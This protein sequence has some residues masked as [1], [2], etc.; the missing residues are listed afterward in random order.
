MTDGLAF[1][2]LGPVEVRV[3][4]RPVDLPAGRQ[5]ALLAALLLADGTVVPVDRLV[6]ALWPDGA[7]PS[8]RNAVQ[9]Y[10]AR[11]RRT[12]GPAGAAV[13]TRPPGYLL[14]ARSAAR[15]D[16]EFLDLVR[17]AEGRLPGAPHEALAG[18]E[19]ALALW[20][21]PAWA[22]F[23]DSFARGEALRLEE[24]RHAA[25]ERRVELL[26]RIGRPDAVAAAE[27]LA[28]DRPL[29][30]R[31]VVLLAEALGAAGRTPEALAALAT[32]RERLREELGLDP[33]VAVTTVQARL[34]RGEVVPPAPVLPAPASVPVP[35]SHSPARPGR[36]RAGRLIGRDRLLATLREILSQASLVSLVGP[37]GVGKTRLAQ[38]VA[39]VSAPSWWVDLAPLRESDL[40]ARA[41]ADAVGVAVHPGGTAHHAL[42]AW[43]AT[44]DGLLVLDNCEH[45]LP[46]AA[47]VTQTVLAAGG[48]SRVLATSRERLGVDGEVVQPVAPLPV[49]VDGD[50]GDPAATDAVKLFLDRARRADPQFAPTV[51]QLTVIGELCRRLDGLPLAIE[52]AAAR[53]RGLAVEDLVARLDARLDLLTSDRRDDDER[54]RT[55]R[56]VIDWSYALLTP[57]ER[58]ALRALGAF[59]GTF[60]LAAAE[61]V[62]EPP[63]GTAADLVVRLVDRSVLHREPGPAP[64]RY[65][66]LES[67]R[68][69]VHDRT[70]PGEVA[71]GRHTRWVRDL[72]AAAEP[73]LN[74]PDEARW[75]ARV[76]AAVPDLRAA[77][78]RA[79][80]AGRPEVVAEVTARL[81][82][83]ACWRL[84]PDLLRW[85]A[86]LPADRSAP[87]LGLAEVA[88]A[89]A[90]WASGDIAGARA[91]AAE[92]A[93]DPVTHPAARAAAY[94]VL[95]DALMGVGRPDRAAEAYA[96]GVASWQA[97]AR[98][99][100][101]TVCA[102]NHALA[103][104][105]AGD[106]T[107]AQQVLTDV[108]AQAA[109]I[110]NPSTT[111]FARY[112]EGEVLADLA[113]DRALAALEDAR[114]LAAGVGN[115][116]ITGVS[117][118]AAVALRGRHGPPDTAL[119]LYA[120]ALA[121]WHRTGPQ[122]LLVTTLRNLMV[123]LVRIGRDQAAAELAA[124]LD[125][126]AADHPSF[127]P[128][129]RRYETARA[130]LAARLDPGTAA[131]AAEVGR[132][133][134]VRQASAAALAVVT[135]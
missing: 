96:R 102:A 134:S 73:E 85:G 4:G 75:A 61:A 117:L 28:A 103:R 131:R 86:G 8:A 12:L 29:A 39:E 98:P 106:E 38:H 130:A 35:G 133:R 25:A 3:S 118:T 69:Y 37:G 97:A 124:T 132:R 108:L 47:E 52:F 2:V 71:L 20:R 44:A 57:D 119:A 120:E 95:G 68:A 91:V 123:L 15:D 6:A 101:A 43:A 24:R 21:G 128:E 26:I 19:Q 53:V 59:A 79:R 22:E 113:P 34:L 74:G 31:P 82:R 17:A 72:L 58:A 41:V 88:V 67:V 125:A 33:G 46:A 84:R 105:F 27:A 9:S 116:L 92:V 104:G 135:G 18:L 63:P 114:R 42:A 110:G 80:H 1:A 45:L 14:D 11:L 78:A 32:Y 99:A 126:H 90:A 87:D 62:L 109:Q 50:R 54:H 23:A 65:R 55:L 40:V 64:A 66:L 129:R 13:R 83:F 77:V 89:S 30:E 49:P 81:W 93:E 7:V 100:D 60:D 122:P 111:A 76:T 121:H 5:R 107:G 48:S 70:G 127:G 112:A 94:E 115:D 10:V 56:K 51:G 36:Y 16:R